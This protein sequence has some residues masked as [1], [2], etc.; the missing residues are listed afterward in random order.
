MLS[1]TALLIPP[2]LTLLASGL[3]HFPQGVASGDVTAESA[4]VWTRADAI[5]DYRL[6]LSRD[7]GFGTLDQSVMLTATDDSDRTLQHDLTGLDSATRYFF[8]FIDLGDMQS[9][10]I[11][12]FQTAPTP[13]D[14]RAF[15]FVYSGDSNAAHRPFRLLD[16]AR[17]EAPDFWVWAGD[18][19]YSDGVADGLPVATDLAGYRAKHRQNRDDPFLQDL[20]A[21]APVIAQWDDHEVANDYDGGE[22]EP[23]I[24][25]SRREA[26]YRAFFEYMP[27]RAQGIP[28]DPHRLYR[29]FRH[30][31]LAEFF[32]LDCR[33][34]RSADLGRSGGGLDPY[35]YFLPTLDLAS[36]CRMR[37]PGRTMLGRE[38]L[39]WL[40]D[41]LRKSEATWKFVL[42]SVPF[43][44]LLVYPFDRWDGYDAERYELF[45][46]IAEQRVTGVVLLSADIHGNA[47][48]PD[49]TH[50]L[51]TSLLEPLPPCPPIREFVAGPI[52]TE[53]TVQEITAVAGMLLGLSPDEAAGALPIALG[54]NLLTSQVAL[55]NG[56]RFLDANHYAYLVVDV[57]PN[58]LELSYRGIEPDPTIAAPTLRTLYSTRIDS[59]LCGVGLALLPLAGTTA[60]AS[61]R[62]M[63]RQPPRRQRHQS[64][65]PIRIT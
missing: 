30:G 38:Q 1:A 3:A 11:G 19:I 22:L 4:I 31:A 18:T 6:E 51:R 15:R 36:I 42:S 17:E 52:A 65:T 60:I 12:T 27:V 14:L 48:N 13:D 63:F 57:S 49:V 50:Y 59:H 21:A 20:L 53:T 64:V 40:R 25:E 45:R 35:G 28:A 23:T 46:F 62:R 7:S 58:A 9:S 26:A 56:L 37:D 44:S 61:M 5:G 32:V 33:Q 47:H 34:Y 2:F 10:P 16:F 8:R 43:T 29:S 24:T 39:E 54:L 55:R 41:G